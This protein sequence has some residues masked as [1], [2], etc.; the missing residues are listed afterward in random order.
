[1]GGFSWNFVISIFFE[2]LSRKF[3][4]HYNLTRITGR[5]HYMKTCGHLWQ[6][7]VQFFLEWEMFCTKVVEKTQTHCTFGTLFPE[8][9]AVYDRMWKNMAQPDR[10]QMPIQYGCKHTLRTCNIYCPSMATTVNA[11]AP[12]RHVIRTVPVSSARYFSWYGVVTTV[13]ERTDL[14]NWHFHTINDWKGNGSNPS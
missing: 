3:K 1:V 10:P 14:N 11:N 13:L 6:Y 4:F 2:N 5:L 8:D 12:Q 7:L 9:R